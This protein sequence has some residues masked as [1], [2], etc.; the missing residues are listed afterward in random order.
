[1]HVSL[2]T[3]STHCCKVTWAEF[4]VFFS[5]NN[6]KSCFAWAGTGNIIGTD[7]ADESDIGIGHGT[8]E[9]GLVM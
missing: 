2:S 3:F 8:W 7:G 5:L 9:E 6:I 4:A 1:M